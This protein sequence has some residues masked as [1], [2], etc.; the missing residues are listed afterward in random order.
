MSAPKV[1]LVHPGADVSVDDVFFGVDA[2]FRALGYTVYQ[3][4]LDDRIAVSGQWM[5]MVWRRNKMETPRPTPADILYKASEELV[6]RALRIQP[7]VVLIV[8]G[9]FLHPDVFVLLRRAG[10]KTALLMTE[11][12]YDDERQKR[13]L[14]RVGIDVVWTNDRASAKAMGIGYMPHAYNPAIHNTTSAIP[15]ETPKHDV[16]FVGT[17]FQERL[18]L[19]SDVDWTGIDLGLYGATSTIPPRSRLR[20]FVKGKYKRNAEA[21]ALCRNAKVSLNLYRQS[22]GFGK[23]APRTCEGESLNPRAYELAAAGCFQISDTR[24]EVSEKF[25]DL[26][27]TFTTAKELSALLHAWVPNAAGRAVRAAAQQAC[28]SGDSWHARVQQMHTD[29]CASGLVAAPRPSA[30]P[31]MAAG[32]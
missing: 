30:P 3:Y 23:H 29:L 26:V 22:R 12:P 19:L 4:P 14:E 16:V 20:P 11:S 25:G 24:P 10:L 27:P 1:L 15:P 8:S 9:M 28:V 2:G 17:Y 18:D 13:I 5:N 32:G 6:C 31:L 21:I 7:D